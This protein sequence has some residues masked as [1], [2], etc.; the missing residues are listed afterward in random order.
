MAKVGR[1][2]V[3]VA[4]R[5][6]PVTCEVSWFAPLCDED[7]EFLG[8]RDDR[9]LSSWEHC[10]GVALRADE[11]GFDNLNLDLMFA[12]PQQTTPLW[13]QTLD[14]AMALG[15]EHLSLYAL[16]L[17]PGTR[18]ER[19]HAGGKLDLPGEDAELEMYERS[20][21]ILTEAGYEHYE[22]SNF[23]R[24]GFRWR[25]EAALPA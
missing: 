6:L 10:R 16:T 17:E 7:F 25:T 20:I 8:V 9:L 5:Q 2:E 19:L 11:A 24:P 14:K 22:V 1:G 18:F 15:T 21:E 3:A 13:E 12:L 23:A 4:W